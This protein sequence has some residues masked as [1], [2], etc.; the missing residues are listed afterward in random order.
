MRLGIE[1]EPGDAKSVYLPGLIAD[2]LDITEHMITSAG[3]PSI[4][5]PP[6]PRGVVAM[7]ANVHLGRLR[8]A[9]RT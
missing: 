2:L 3:G 7:I 5:S 1:P 6:G 4:T 8:E 9:G